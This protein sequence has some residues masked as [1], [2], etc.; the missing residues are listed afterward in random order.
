MITHSFNQVIVFLH[1]T[2]DVIDRTDINITTS[3]I[4]HL[5]TRGLGNCGRM[6]VL[7]TSVFTIRDY[8]H[9][10]FVVCEFNYHPWTGVLD[11]TVWD[12]VCKRNV[13]GFLRFLT[14][15]KLTRVKSL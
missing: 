12:K 10:T 7:F 15:I 11:I 1:T 5:Y 8:H 4:S 6:I 13:C 14:Q 9:L 3:L 2:A